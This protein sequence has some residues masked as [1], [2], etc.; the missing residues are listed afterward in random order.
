MSDK[1]SL[2]LQGVQKKVSDFV[3]AADL[4]I[5]P[6]QRAVLTGRSGSGKTTLLR[7]IAGL[8][9]L[10]ESGGQGRIWVGSEEIT[11]LTPQRRNIGVVFQDLG[12]FPS[13]DVL[14]NVTFALRMRGL[15]KDEREAQ[16]IPWLRKVGLEKLIHA[17]IGRLSGGEAQR[18]A[19]VRALIWR[20]RILLLDEPFS[21][22]DPELRATLRSELLELHQL[23]PVP[24]ILV[25]HDAE[26]AQQLATLQL[27]VSEEPLGF[28][29]IRVE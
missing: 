19:F 9:S 16:A 27:K 14:D 3:L 21:A 13:L 10:H 4:V 25:S 11:H 12:L 20:P 5:D 24:M 18:V 23:W 28:R 15:S 2:R 6:G 17:S 8:E 22:L 1:G 29:R 7:L 26:D